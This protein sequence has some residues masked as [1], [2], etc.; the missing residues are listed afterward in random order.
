MRAASREK[1]CSLL[2]SLSRR[3]T[4]T[5]R[6]LRAFEASVEALGLEVL[7]LYLLHWPMPKVFE[8]T[9]A[10]WVAA[11]RLLA[12]G[13]VRAIG[14]CNF[15][16][17]HLASL[18][19]CSSV[20]PALNQVELHLFLVQN[21]LREAH[22][23]HGVV[24]QAWSPLGGVNRYWKSGEDPLTHPVILQIAAWY[25]K[26]AAQVILRW[27]L[28]R[29]VSV[30]P[31]SLKS[32]RIQENFAVLDFVLGEGEIEEINALDQHRRGGPD[33]DTR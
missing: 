29:G 6:T 28:Q 18:M 2:P 9:L 7:D 23:Q 32:E 1:M 33:P 30:I 5:N 8:T 21:A 22:H 24:T 3:T 14:V 15:R 27:H 26:T 11:E 16:E 12:E 10:S 13:R 17:T 25:G 31:K 4:G 19:A 20:V